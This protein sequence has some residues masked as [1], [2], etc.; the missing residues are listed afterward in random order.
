MIEQGNNSFNLIGEYTCKVD[1]KSRVRLPGEVVDQLKLID[2]Q[3]FI[4][5][6]GQDGQI[7][8]FPKPVWDLKLADLRRLNQFDSEARDFIRLFM[9]GASI[10]KLDANNRLLIPKKLIEY[11]GIK[12]EISM[13]GVFDLFEIWDTAKYEADVLERPKEDFKQLSQKVMVN[14][15]ADDKKE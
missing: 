11:A 4:M 14:K 9:R 5:N 7:L 12:K 15:P 13:L 10:V 2:N 6:R 3:S 8:L 1:A